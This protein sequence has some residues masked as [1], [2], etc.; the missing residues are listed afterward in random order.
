MIN[1]RK[2]IRIKEFPGDIDVKWTKENI[3]EFRKEI[4]NDNQKLKKRIKHFNYITLCMVVAIFSVF[5]ILSFSLLSFSINF[6]L[7]IFICFLV[8]KIHKYKE[9]ILF[10]NIF[11][12]IPD[13]LY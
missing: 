1:K 2:N 11:K 9:Y 10:N 12:S 6:L 5:K 7:L 8:Y 3:E 13:D 4:D